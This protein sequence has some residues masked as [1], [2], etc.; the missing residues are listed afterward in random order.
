MYIYAT[1]R[2]GTK[3]G[4]KFED[5]DGS[6]KLMVDHMRKLELHAAYILEFPDMKT[7]QREEFQTAEA[8]VA[9]VDALLK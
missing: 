2:I 9:G 6:K 7:E 5:D 4:L 3:Y 8:V 1:D